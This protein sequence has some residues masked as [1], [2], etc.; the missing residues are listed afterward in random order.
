MPVFH[1]GVAPDYSHDVQGASRKH[2]SNMPFTYCSYR[3]DYR[4]DLSPSLETLSFSL[5]TLSSIDLHRNDF[6]LIF[7]S[8]AIWVVFLRVQHRHRDTFAGK[9]VEQIRDKLGSFILNNIR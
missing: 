7:Q 2:L 5:L 6:P 1:I 8:R 3:P 4:T 9:R